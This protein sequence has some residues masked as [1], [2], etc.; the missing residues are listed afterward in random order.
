[1]ELRTL[2][3]LP[4]C[5]FLFHVFKENKKVN[6]RFLLY[7]LSERIILLLMRTM[8]RF[9]KPIESIKLSGLRFSKVFQ[10]CIYVRCYTASDSQT[11]RILSPKRMHHC[12]YECL[13]ENKGCPGLMIVYLRI[14][15]KVIV[16]STLI[17]LEDAIKYNFRR[18]RRFQY[19]HTLFIPVF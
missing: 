5:G 4:V 3:M 10:N 19:C 2:E 14:D 17:S 6:L 16:Q 9:C 8:A 12:K 18:P 11:G 15:Q 1:M 7:T 13:L